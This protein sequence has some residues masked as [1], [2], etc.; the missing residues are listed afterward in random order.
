MTQTIRTPDQITDLE[1][2]RAAWAMRAEVDPVS[3]ALGRLSP[4]GAFD[5]MRDDFAELQARPEY[6]AWEHDSEDVARLRARI[7]A[8]LDGYR[9]YQTPAA[10][11]SRVGRELVQGLAARCWRQG[12]VTWDLVEMILREDADMRDLAETLGYPGSTTLA[13]I[14]PA[15]Q[16][17]WR[18]IADHPDRS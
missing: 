13:E 17:A 12:I 9:A 10:L 7:E 11:A 18:E 2:Q 8:A 14:V 1:V 6:Q 5:F 3:S 15:V 4:R 16:A